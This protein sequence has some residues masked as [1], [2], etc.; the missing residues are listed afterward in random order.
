MN[1]LNPFQPV[2]INIES[3]DIS[4]TTKKYWKMGHNEVDTNSDLWIIG[5]HLHHEQGRTD[6]GAFYQVMKFGILEVVSITEIEK[7]EYF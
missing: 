3:V 2:G 1:C 6:P 5:L 7:K 4:I